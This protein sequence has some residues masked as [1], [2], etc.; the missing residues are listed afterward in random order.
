MKNYKIKR[1]VSYL[2]VVVLL[3][4]WIGIDIIYL[5][6]GALPRTLFEDSITIFETYV[7][8]AVGTII[9]CAI[10]YKTFLDWLLYVVVTVFLCFSAG[11]IFFLLTE[12]FAVSIFIGGLAYALMLFFVYPTL[13][14]KQPE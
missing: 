2:L 13:E 5:T 9:I 8:I 11:F 14:I 1:I 12:S 6:T 3:F 4:A 7:A 10:I